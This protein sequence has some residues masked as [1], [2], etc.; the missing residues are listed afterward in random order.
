MCI[1]SHSL[2]VTYTCAHMHAHPETQL[3][4]DNCT[5][6]DTSNKSSLFCVSTAVGTCIPTH[7]LTVIECDAHSDTKIGSGMQKLMGGGSQSYVD[8]QMMEIT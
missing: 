2:A 3:W 5:E 4:Y 7:G 6:K 1:P 8:T